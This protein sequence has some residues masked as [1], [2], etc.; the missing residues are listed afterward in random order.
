MRPDKI[1]VY[2]LFDKQRRYAVPL[3][4]RPY[5]W[6]KDQQWQPLWED[7]CEKATQVQRR[8]ANAPHFLGAIVTSQRQV[9]GNDISAWD[10]ID[11]QQ[12]LTTLQVLLKAFRDVLKTLG[13]TRFD[14]DLS[15]ITQNE[16][17][18][19]GP[20]ERFKVW[21][22]NVDRAVFQIVMEAG[23]IDTVL[24]A[25]PG[26]RGRQRRAVPRLA[27]A[28]LFFYRAIEGYAGEPE[29]EDAPGD[30]QQRLE[31]LFETFRR[32]VYL[33]NIELESG[34]DPQV[35]FESLNGRG[36][37]LLPSDLVR[38]FV[39]MKASRAAGELDALY[40]EY[41]RQYDERRS[42]GNSGEPWWKEEERQGRLKRPRL[43]LFL[44]HYLQYRLR[45]EV[46]IGHLF[47][48]FRNWWDQSAGGSVDESLGDMRLYSD[49]FA[50]WLEPEGG[51]RLS[52]FGRWLRAL[53]TSTVYPLLFYIAVESEGRTTTEDRDGIIDDLESYLVRR[54]VCGL[55][56]KQYNRFFLTLLRNLTDAP[57][58]RESFRKHLIA[59]TGDS[60]RWPNDDEFG[61]AFVHR[62]A[63]QVLK[64][65]LVLMVLRALDKAL[66]TSMHEDIEVLS[67]LS[68]EH[69]MP[70][71]WESAWPLA[72]DTDE[73]R[74]RRERMLHS[75][76]N[77]GLVT[78]QFN[79]SLSNRGFDRKQKE[80]RR[81]MRLLV[82]DVIREADSWDE[83][84]ILERGRLLFD[85]A[86][87]RWPHPTSPATLGDVNLDSPTVVGWSD[88]TLDAGPEE[89]PIDI[90]AATALLDA[91]ASLQRSTS[92]R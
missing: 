40:D 77:L 62:P 28:Y 33:V 52:K 82:N 56:N 68:I 27:E 64:R 10:I 39:F 38:N 73:S 7:V 54:A 30:T 74:E 63:Y 51:T 44:F 69:V 80:F 14:L 43:D 67:K 88:A 46:N 34:D 36:I 25:Y 16:G 32:Y 49:A 79:A 37:P 81:I 48:E 55:T 66:M 65:E 89:P 6:T 1:S 24:H 2:E 60:V 61:R 47:Q 78:P 9:F 29:S 84:A 87:R 5:V 72:S 76:G 3:Y 90:P 70:Q 92:T 35:I 23:S 85:L 31:A 22:T 86:R 57:L 42:E 59:A 20:L 71:S 15:R 75:F 53:D 4:Q 8:E 11:G 12:R 58:T 21:P 19:G 13:Q 91:F 41:W 45:R 26:L 18:M 50:S 17:V 83:E